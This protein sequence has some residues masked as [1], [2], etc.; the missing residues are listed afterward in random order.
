MALI[1]FSALFG[2]AFLTRL[3]TR[4]I[5][6]IDALRTVRRHLGYICTAL[7]VLLAVPLGKAARAETLT[8][9]VT[10]A[11]HNSNARQ[12]AVE[13]IK[14]QAQLVAIRQSERGARVELFGEIAAEIV[15][16]PGTPAQASSNDPQIARQI[17]FGV[18]YTLLD[19]MRSLNAVYKEA[20]LLDAEIL[21]LADETE[22]LALRV[23]QAFLDITRHSN[24][25]REATRNVVV[26]ERI[27]RQV[28]QQVT[29]GK[30]SESDNFRAEEKVLEAK[31]AQAETNTSLSEAI[32]QFD[33]LTGSRPQGRLT[34]AK[35]VHL[36]SSR[37]AFVQRAV[38][39]NVQLQLAQSNIDA[40]TYQKTI[41]AAEWKPR[42]N[43]FAGGFTG[44]N[45]DGARGNE[46]NLGV[47]VRMNWTLHK[48][49]ARKATEARNRDLLMRAHYQKK[50]IEDEV[51]AFASQSWISF[52]AARERMALISQSVSKS[53]EIAEAYRREFA[54]AKRPLLQVLEA[55][56]DLFNLRVRQHNARAA[57]VFQQY[58][59]LAAQNTLSAHFGLAHAGRPMAANF[60]QRVK[61]APR[62]RFDVSAPDLQ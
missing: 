54:A 24:I 22:T 28:N 50:Q 53:T 12:A 60:Q 8:A 21:R 39:N 30:L 37:D 45:L 31:L 27:A 7:I 25:V 17:G 38:A 29:L 4:D 32:A 23:V 57:V 48:G 3:E 2:S 33:F 61:S 52:R 43:L 47:G 36:P 15:D 10:R 9:A 35:Q 6:G 56:R 16:D 40:L 51:R 58:K 18:E 20:T 62:D 46:S 1:L 14:A 55:E 13:A 59:I 42:V 34:I 5:E 41:D 44:R 19:G 26:H 49:G 11:A